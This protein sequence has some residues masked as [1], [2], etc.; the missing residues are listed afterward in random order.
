MDKRQSINWVE[1]IVKY[2]T[3]I[4]SVVGVLFTLV[5]RFVAMEHKL[6]ELTRTM[7]RLNTTV[8]SLHEELATEKSTTA[9]LSLRLSVL[10]RETTKPRLAEP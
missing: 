8:T 9:L 10:E 3:F 7:E 2:G 4:T 1:L 6:E 5:T